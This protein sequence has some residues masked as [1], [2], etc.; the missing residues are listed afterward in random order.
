MSDDKKDITESGQNSADSARISWH[1]DSMQITY[2]NVVN[3]TSTREELS[4]FFG[5][6]KTWDLEEIQEII[7][8][9]THR[10]LLNPYTAKRL[11]LLLNRV[12]EEYE[13]RFGIL[14]VGEK[15]H[16]VH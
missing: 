14:G 6:N 2:S 13:F 7:V 16:T 1:H 9:L 12:V 5:T 10:V 3:V 15:K 8:E 4:I 11:L